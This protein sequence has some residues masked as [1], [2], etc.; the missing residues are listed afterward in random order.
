MTET[1]GFFADACQTSHYI[2]LHQ[3]TEVDK[4]KICMPSLVTD[5][6]SIR[7]SYMF[8]ALTKVLMQVF[9]NLNMPSRLGIFKAS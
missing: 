2:T 3:D 1:F 6:P 9:P 5:L 7:D 4:H 8:W